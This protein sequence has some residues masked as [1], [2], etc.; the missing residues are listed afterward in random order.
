MALFKGNLWSIVLPPEWVGEHD[1]DCATIYNPDGAGALQISAYS[2]NGDVT[3]EDLMGLANEY[4]PVGAKLTR[5]EV[6]QFSGY[7][8][9]VGLEGQFWQYWFCKS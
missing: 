7:S 6:G 2:K 9:A 5:I 1:E 8:V 3:K 4:I